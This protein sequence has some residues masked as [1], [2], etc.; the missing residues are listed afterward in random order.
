MNQDTDMAFLSICCWLFLL[1]L[2]R[3]LS[4]PLSLRFDS[5]RTNEERNLRCDWLNALS[6]NRCARCLAYELNYFFFFFVFTK[7]NSS[8]SH[9]YS[10][11][12]YPPRSTHTHIAS[13]RTRRVKEI[14]SGKRKKNRKRKNNRLFF[15]WINLTD[16]EQTEISLHRRQSERG[17][18]KKVQ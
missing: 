18:K 13:K 3:A 6:F 17:E 11:V 1:L 2:S 8:L 12:S 7:N 15:L 9:H 5:M 14:A 16:V 10:V 4:L